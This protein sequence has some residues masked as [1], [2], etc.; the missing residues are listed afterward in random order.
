[1]LWKWKNGYLWEKLTFVRALGQMEPCIKRE[2]RQN[3]LKRKPGNISSP[4]ITGLMKYEVALPVSSL[5]MCSQISLLHSY[6]PGFGDELK[7]KQV[8]AKRT[9]WSHPEQ[10]SVICYSYCT[11]SD[12]AYS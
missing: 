11:D 1:M 3:L 10:I 12:L 4:S 9:C 5:N 2:M 6:D 8:N 7:P